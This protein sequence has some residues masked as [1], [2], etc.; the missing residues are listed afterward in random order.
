MLRKVNVSVFLVL[1]DFCRFLTDFAQLYLLHWEFPGSAQ[2]APRF[3][4]L[5]FIVPVGGTRCVT[6]SIDRIVQIHARI[7]W[8]VVLILAIFFIFFFDV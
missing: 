6:W 3:V 2:L 5:V 8:G 4:K 1:K 7:T